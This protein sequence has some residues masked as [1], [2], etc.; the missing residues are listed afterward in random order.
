MAD[1]GRPETTEEEKRAMAQKLEPYLKSGLS[2]RKALREAQIPRSTFYDILQKDSDFSD[3]IERFKQFLSIM[4][5][6]AI[7]THLQNIIALQNTPLTEEQI[8]QGLKFQPI[9]KEDVDFIKWFSTNSNLTREEYGERR[10]ISAF[11]PE[12]ELNKI[13]EFID[14][15]TT[16]D[17]KVP[18]DNEPKNE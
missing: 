2:I 17:T 10:E 3:Q 6:N 15:H 14:T 16:K 4:N 8:K 18:F 11:D 5:N 13:K 9:P 7:V 12:E 1:I